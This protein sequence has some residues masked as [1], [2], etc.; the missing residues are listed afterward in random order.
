MKRKLLVILLE[1]AYGEISKRIISKSTV[2]RTPE[3]IKTK[4]GYGPM[5]KN[6]FFWCTETFNLGLRIVQERI[7]H[8]Y[9]ANHP[10]QVKIDFLRV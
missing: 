10:L 8:Y 7:C 1:E 6:P 2:K 9:H 4:S 3:E 5:A